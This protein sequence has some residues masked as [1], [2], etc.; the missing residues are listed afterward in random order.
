MVNLRSLEREASMFGSP[1]IIAHRALTPGAIPNSV[2][3][4][5]S[6][7]D[8]GADLVELDV[9]LSLD[10]KPVLVH[11]AMLRH[12]T[13]G[14][15]WVRLWPNFGLR[16]LR[17]L[18]DAD[19]PIQTL[20]EALEVPLSGAQLALHLKDR[21]ALG[22]VLRRLH[23]A[24]AASRTWLWLERPGDVITATRRLPD[25]R[26]T[27]LRPKGWYPDEYPSYVAEAQWVGAAAISLPAGVISQE[28]VRTA[29]QHH[30]RVFTRIDE[31]QQAPPLSAIGVD[32]FITTD[33]R[34]TRLLLAH[35]GHLMQ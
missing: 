17:L 35:S 16:R 33:S 30:L 1:L 8:A 7:I 26:V 23:E 12:T 19:H 25:L 32:G 2:A 9:R 21:G 18:L 22:P 27:L 3:S 29:H 14:R 13:T 6:A 11:D 15:G 28:M 34:A 20:D 31:P 10:R 24:K 5:S 4:V